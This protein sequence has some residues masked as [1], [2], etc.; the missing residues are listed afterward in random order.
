M[1]SEDVNGQREIVGM[2]F[3]ILKVNEAYQYSK[4]ATVGGT[5]FKS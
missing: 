4:S 2:F 1:L 5:L 3:G